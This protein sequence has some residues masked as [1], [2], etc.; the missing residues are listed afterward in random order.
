[1]SAILRQKYVRTVLMLVAGLL[2][3]LTFFE[4]NIHRGSL[5]GQEPY[6]ELVHVK[7]QI[8]EIHI[9]QQPISRVRQASVLYPPTQKPGF[10]FAFQPITTEKLFL[11]HR[12]MRI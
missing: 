7:K 11:V 6:H 1:M 8:R 9:T 10:L 12:N 4:T 3:V 5:P 2:L